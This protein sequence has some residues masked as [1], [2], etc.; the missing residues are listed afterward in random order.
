MENFS[1]RLYYKLMLG[2]SMEDLMLNFKEFTLKNGLNLIVLKR[3]SRFFNLNFGIK[4]GS[5]Y[6]MSNERG[7]SHFIEHMLFRSNDEFRDYEI[8]REIEFLG[9]DYDA[10]T[11]YGSTILSITSLCED[12][13]KAIKLFSSMVMHPKFDDKEIDIERDVIIS[14]INSSYAN[15]EEFSFMELNKEAFNNFHVKYDIA[16]DKDLL[17]KVRSDDLKAFYDKYY[18]PNNAYAVVISSYDEEFVFELFKKYF[19]SWQNKFLK[20]R[21]LIHESNI[22][23]TIVT[24]KKDIDISTITYLFTFNNLK[25]HDKTLLKLVEYKLG[26]SPNSILFHEIRDKHGL[27]YDVYTQLELSNE[28]N[29]MYIFCTANNEDIDKVKEIIDASID[30]L[31]KANDNFDDYN[32]NLMKK[33]QLM[34]IYS[35]FEDYSKLG[36]YTVEKMIYKE[37]IYSYLDNLKI[38]EKVNSQQLIDISNKYLNDPTVHILKRK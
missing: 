34:S 19:G 18:L 14:E 29:G 12:L 28:F 9:G 13:D 8:N 5:A 10:F 7:F 11:D 38:I 31:K 23:K 15:Y 6:E 24:K 26:G 16:G 33:L 3:N 37:N 4:V 1:K 30:S 20:H 36:L 35:I 25:E 32:L 27:A 22:K 21:D 2:E 17:V